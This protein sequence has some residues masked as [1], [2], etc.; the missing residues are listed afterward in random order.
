MDSSMREQLRRWGFRPIDT[1]GQP[2]TDSE[3]QQLQKPQQQEP[4]DETL[5]IAKKL[6]NDCPDVKL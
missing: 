5:E 6:L 4:S 2:K 1:N 3:P